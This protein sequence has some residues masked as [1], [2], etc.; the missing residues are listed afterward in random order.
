M[1]QV[2][3]IKN[4]LNIVD[5]IRE[6]IPQMKQAG[7]NWKALC[8]FHTEKTPSFMISEDKQFWHCFGCGEGGDVFE[9]IKKIENVDFSESLRMTGPKSRSDFKK[10]GPK[11]VGFKI[12]IY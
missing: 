4:K 2:Q 6:Y 5:V 10:T 9:F 8:P 1:D 3:E 11:I 7:T 12:T